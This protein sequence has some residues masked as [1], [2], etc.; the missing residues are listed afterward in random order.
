MPGFQIANKNNTSPKSAALYYYF[1][2]ISGSLLPKER[3][4]Q[5]Y[6]F[7]LSRINNKYNIIDCDTGFRNIGRKNLQIK[8]TTVTVKAKT[9]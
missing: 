1:K 7:H 8:N 3:L 5:S 6:L 9:T 4:S 2:I